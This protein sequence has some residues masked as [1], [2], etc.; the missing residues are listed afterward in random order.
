MRCSAKTSGS[1]SNGSF[2]DG[3]AVGRPLAT[4]RPAAA[5]EHSPRP[6]TVVARD[7]MDRN[8]V[9]AARLLG[10][11]TVWL[12]EAC[13]EHRMIAAPR[14]C[15]NIRTVNHSTN[16]VRMTGDHRR[17]ITTTQIIY[18]FFTRGTILLYYYYYPR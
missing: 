7:R 2:V 12:G 11:G 15:V 14:T 10:A 5:V 9:R 6:S 18:Y 4:R 17:R 13:K 16:R 1:R 3:R 8:W